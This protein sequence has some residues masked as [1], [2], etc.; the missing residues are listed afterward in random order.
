MATIPTWARNPKQDCSSPFLKLEPECKS[1]PISCPVFLLFLLFSAGEHSQG[2][3]VLQHQHAGF[4]G[5]W[6]AVIA[7]VQVSGSLTAS[8][9]LSQCPQFM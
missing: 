2:V 4:C 6:K 1:H 3:E 9:E 7:A 5:R 8:L